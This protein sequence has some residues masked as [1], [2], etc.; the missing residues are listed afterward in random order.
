M[1]LYK[2]EN[3]NGPTA[4]QFRHYYIFKGDK[5][6]LEVTEKNRPTLVAFFNSK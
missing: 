4:V 2:Y 3:L 1:K 5:Y 6:V